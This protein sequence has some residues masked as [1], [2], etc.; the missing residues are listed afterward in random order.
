VAPTSTDLGNRRTNPQRTETLLEGVRRGEE[1]SWRLL[2]EAH[3]DFLQ[4]VLSTLTAGRRGVDVDEV[5]QVTFV[6]AWRNIDAFE[7]RGVGSLR[8][9]LRRIAENAFVDA[10]RADP[11]AHAA[12]APAED[13]GDGG[14]RAP[15]RLAEE[16]ELTAHLFACLARL[17]PEDRDVVIMRKL[18][19]LTWEEISEIEGRPRT[20]VRRAF[21]QA[22]DRLQAWM[23]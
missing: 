22:I 6:R 19:G 16:R 5:L 15:G 12:G 17:S 4:Y 2:F 14:R 23:S 9:W 1:E 7:Y 13:L 8:R 3:R 10:L 18:E 11:G 21:E 20:S